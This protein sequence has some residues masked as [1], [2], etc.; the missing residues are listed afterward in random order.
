M[1]LTQPYHL[2]FES[3]FMVQGHCANTSGEHFI[4]GSVN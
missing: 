4:A 1:Q 2:Q 3:N